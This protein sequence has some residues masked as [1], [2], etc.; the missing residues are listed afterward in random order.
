MC[1]STKPQLSTLPPSVGP[2]HLCDLRQTSLH[3]LESSPRRR[4][5]SL[6]AIATPPAARDEGVTRLGQSQLSHLEVRFPPQRSTPSSTS[7]AA[8]G[9]AKHN[10][11]QARLPVV[12]PPIVN[13]PAHSCNHSITSALA[14]HS[15]CTP[16]PACPPLQPLRSPA[17]PLTHSPARS[18]TIRCDV[19]LTL[20][21]AC[22]L[23]M[24]DLPGDTDTCSKAVCAHLCSAQRSLVPPSSLSPLLS[25]VSPVSSWPANQGRSRGTADFRETAAKFQKEWRV[26]APHRHFEF[27]SHVKNYSLVSVLNKGL[28]YHGLERDY[29]QQRV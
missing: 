20:D 22:L 21:L 6:S 28:I 13:S 5:C 2:H 29:A 8:H 4:H 19:S 11:P 26:E 25:L 12:C 17:C 1:L 24:P 9:P 27:A 10:S 23:T 18:L 7:C 15:R 14:F 16:S 3:T